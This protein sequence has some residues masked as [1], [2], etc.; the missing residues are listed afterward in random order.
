[1]LFA[2]HL[3]LVMVSDACVTFS[4]C[5]AG[6]DDSEEGFMDGHYDYGDSERAMR[7]GQMQN[8]Y[9]MMPGNMSVPGNFYGQGAMG[10]MGGMGVGGYMPPG[11]MGAGMGWQGGRPDQGFRQQSG[12]PIGRPGA[13][14]QVHLVLLSPLFL[15]C[16]KG[17]S[18]SYSLVHEFRV[19]LCVGHRPVR[20]AA[21]NRFSCL[22][23][24]WRAGRW[25]WYGRRRGHVKA[26]PSYPN[27]DLQE[28]V[29]P[30]PHHDHRKNNR[31]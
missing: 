9:G 11:Q 2:L 14:P 24:R 7:Q 21:R 5:L 3:F 31:C 29:T 8:A 16:P 23:G 10:G 20:Q 19:L 27:V 17:I 25:W 28:H 13:Q 22:D 1:M 26:C 15:Y 4:E 12:A 18:I 6:K 30:P